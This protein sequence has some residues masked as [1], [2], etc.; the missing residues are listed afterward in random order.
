M[1]N[2]VKLNLDVSCDMMEIKINGKQF[3]LGNHWD[4]S[5]PEDIVRLISELGQELIV[6]YDWEYEN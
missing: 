5:R 3:F 6:D 2:K 1:K 4:F